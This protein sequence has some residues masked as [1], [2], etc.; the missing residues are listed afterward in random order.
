MAKITSARDNP[1]QAFG[2][3]T[4]P[5]AFRILLSYLAVAAAVYVAQL[6]P[7]PG[8]FLTMMLAGL[9]ISIILNLMLLHLARSAI[10]RDIPRAWLLL[11]VLVYGAFGGFQVVQHLQASRELNELESA[12]HI[13]GPV[14]RSLDLMFEKGDRFAFSARKFILSGQVFAGDSEIQAIPTQQAPSSDCGGG[15]DPKTSDVDAP[16]ACAVSRAGS[17]PH[18][19]LRFHQ[20]VDTGYS[21]TA[22]QRTD[23]AIESVDDD[24]VSKPV[25]RFGFGVVATISPWPFFW[26][27]CALDDHDAGA[28]RCGFRPITQE[29]HYG[30][31]AQPSGPPGARDWDA[32]R[33][34][35]LGALLGWPV[36]ARPS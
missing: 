18:A 27:R 26:L 21:P 8:V 6:L 29:T 22:G 28:W 10:T 11:P 20:R 15:G 19:G 5:H 32:V 33:A 31:S 16:N 9:W 14:A 7:V 30:V 12:N 34:Q 1:S 4:P 25:G 13:D 2:V 35:A 23:Y 24:G 17:G 36:R 3:P